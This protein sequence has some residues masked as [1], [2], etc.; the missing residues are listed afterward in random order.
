ME[1]LCT[2]IVSLEYNEA[3]SNT[4]KNCQIALKGAPLVYGPCQ[5]WTQLFGLHQRGVQESSVLM[6]S[7]HPH[8]IFYQL[9]IMTSY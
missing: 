9:D 5:V 4:N 6:L 3:V 8:Q 7:W 1:W 2:D